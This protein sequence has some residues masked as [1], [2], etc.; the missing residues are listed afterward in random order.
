[1]EKKQSELCLEILRRFHKTGILDD[2]ILL[3]R[4][5]IKI[6]LVHGAI[7]QIQSVLPEFQEGQHA[8]SGVKGCD[9][10]DSCR[11]DAF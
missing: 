8:H 6:I 2:L 9:C 3:Q 4:I 10:E 1:M 5:G 7:P 11:A